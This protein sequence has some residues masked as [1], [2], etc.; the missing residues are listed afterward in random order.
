[1]RRKLFRGWFIVGLAFLVM[2]LVFGSRFSLGLFIP[3]LTEALGVSVG[4][5]SLVL[6]ISTLISGVTQP[7]TGVVADRVGPSRVIL[8]GLA[9]MGASFVGT[10]L[11]TSFWQFFLLMGIA[12]GLAFSATNLVI[13]AALIS[14]W[15][16][17]GRG[18]ALGLVASGSKIGSLII[19]PTA[20]IAIVTLGWRA[21]LIM[22]GVCML[23]LAPLIW[24]YMASDPAE[25]GLLADGAIA[26]TGAEAAAMV[27][28]AAPVAESSGRALTD[29]RRTIAALVRVPAFWL[30]SISLFGN[31]FLMNLVYLHMPSYML[32]A[33]YGELMATGILALMAGIGIFGSIVTGALSDVV[34]R[35]LILAVL[36]LA[37]TAATLLLV[38]YPSETTVYVFAVIFGFLGYGA[39]AVTSTLTG[40]VFGRHSLGSV[41]GVMYVLHQLGGGLGIYAGGLSVDL[42]GSYTPALWL[43]VALSTVSAVVIL[44][45]K[46]EPHRVRMLV[47]EISA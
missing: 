22:L 40:D 8:V 7:L 10:G 27:G 3:G 38:L 2:L 41:F 18:R 37:R 24:R 26:P 35:K 43:C 31:G 4:S 20:G 47:R 11:A 28:A 25:M 44:R 5:V 1:V 34:P 33:G 17:R 14:R 16:D 39:V 21:T 36:Y 13:L 23:A 30:L 42:T 32:K 9:A 46:A 6:A 45:V 15:F 29:L 19:V 12:S